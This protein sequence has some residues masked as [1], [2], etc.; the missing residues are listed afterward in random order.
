MPPGVPGAMP[1]IQE[2]GD[3]VL[4][5][6]LPVVAGQQ[7]QH[8]PVPPLQARAAHPAAPRRPGPASPAPPGRWRRGARPPRPARPARPGRYTTRSP[9]TRP[10]SPGSWVSRRASSGPAPRI[11][12]TSRHASS[13][14]WVSAS[15][16][17]PSTATGGHLHPR[18][19]PPHRYRRREWLHRDRSHEPPREGHGRGYRRGRPLLAG[20][21]VPLRPPLRRAAL[22]RHVRWPEPWV[23][24]PG[25]AAW[26]RPEP[27]TWLRALVAVA[28]RM[29]ISA[30]AAPG[31]LRARAICRGGLRVDPAV[32]RDFKVRR[33]RYWSRPLGP[34]LCRCPATVWCAVYPG[35]RA[36]PPRWGRPGEGS[37][38]LRRR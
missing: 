19:S 18:T 22:I 24:A 34:F 8:P 25:T 23:T 13:P 36:G 26:L 2:G 15:S 11:A 16:A 30:R 10:S 3:H 17:S 5:P 35:R 28:A 32:Y 1:A 21:R 29:L 9:G 33:C 37:S 31:Q 12:T 27:A 38:A 6:L 20:L 7:P 4:L 14:I